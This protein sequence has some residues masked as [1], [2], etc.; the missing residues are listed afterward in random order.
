MKSKAKKW[1]ILHKKNRLLMSRFRVSGV[2][3]FN[4]FQDAL[5]KNFADET[6]ELEWNLKGWK[7]LWI[8][9]RMTKYWMFN[10]RTYYLVNDNRNDVIDLVYPS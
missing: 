9:K 1:E 3:A 4:S 6:I 2:V 10:I 5:L 7:K 8:L